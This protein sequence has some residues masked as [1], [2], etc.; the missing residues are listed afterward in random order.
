[1]R[2][3]IIKDRKFNQVEIDFMKNTINDQRQEDKFS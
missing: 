2:S 1:M 3:I